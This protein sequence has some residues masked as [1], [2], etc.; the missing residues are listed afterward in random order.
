MNRFDRK[1]A[2]PPI[3]SAYGRHILICVGD[4]CDPNGHGPQLYRHLTRCLGDLMEYTN[5][6]RAKRG[7]VEC[8]GVCTGGPIVVV[9]PD[10][11]WYH[12]VTEAVLERIVEEHLRGGRP[13]EEHIF[14]RM[15]TGQKQPE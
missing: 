9:Y 11:I 10:G 13:V 2:A 12:H 14:Y 4:S 15:D 7:K 3:M 6:G 5:P 1:P 8:L